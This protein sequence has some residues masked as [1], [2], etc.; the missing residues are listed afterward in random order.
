MDSFSIRKGQFCAVGERHSTTMVH[1]ATGESWTYTVGRVRRAS[2]KGDR[3]KE[4]TVYRYGTELRCREDEQ[5][6]WWQSYSILGEEMQARAAALLGREFS[7]IDQLRAA[8]VGQE[9]DR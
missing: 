1:G 3:I 7:T 2:A 5:N 6:R 9:N 4:A 8:L